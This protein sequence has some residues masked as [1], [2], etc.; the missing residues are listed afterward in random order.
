AGTSGPGT[1]AGTAADVPAPRTA[2]AAPTAS[3]ARVAWHSATVPAF[4]ATAGPP[5]W[6][7]E[8]SPCSP[9]NR[10]DDPARRLGWV[11]SPP[12]SSEG[13]PSVPL[14]LHTGDGSRSRART[15]AYSG[16]RVK[17]G[18]HEVDEEQVEHRHRESH[19]VDDRGTGASPTGRRTGVQVR[20]VDHPGHE[21]D[22]LLGVPTPEPTPR[23]LGPH[24]AAQ[25]AE[26]EHREREHGRP[27]S[28][29]VED[30][31][32][33]QFRGEPAEFHRVPVMGR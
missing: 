4:P 20:G 31:G 28:D 32:R 19:D 23:R 27:V 15:S 21:G 26:G 25:D 13:L 6:G 18:R 16:I 5:K 22:G 1:A 14:T 8:S 10:E 17:T 24:G 30:V 9:R 29:L 7:K 11:R 3:T 12:Q 2:W 33:R